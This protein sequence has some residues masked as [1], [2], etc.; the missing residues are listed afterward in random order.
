MFWPRGF[1]PLP[2]SIYMLPS[3]LSGWWL[4]CNRIE[5][6]SGGLCGGAENR[7]K[8]MTVLPRISRF[9]K[10][11]SPGGTVRGAGTRAGNAHKVGGQGRDIM[12]TCYVT[13]DYM[14]I[15]GTSRD[16]VEYGHRPLLQVPPF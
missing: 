4:A 5:P 14:A 3:L 8:V 1:P 15:Y 12:E 11:D 2:L 10:H 7:W 9:L 16:C 13:C 6:R